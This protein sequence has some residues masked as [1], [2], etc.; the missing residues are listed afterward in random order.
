MFIIWWIVC[1]QNTFKSRSIVSFLWKLWFLFMI[2]RQFSNITLKYN[3]AVYLKVGI[4]MGNWFDQAFYFFKY[5]P[6]EIGQVLPFEF[7][8]FWSKH[9][10]FKSYVFRS[11][12]SWCG[13]WCH[14]KSGLNKNG[15]N[16]RTSLGT[17][18]SYGTDISYNYNKMGSYF[19]SE[20]CK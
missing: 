5:N 9:V 4:F 18:C 15:R 16:N 3:V 14:A 17:R 10:Q 1:G 8:L 20:V 12:W 19:H 6:V 13:I 7:V 11:K 2:M